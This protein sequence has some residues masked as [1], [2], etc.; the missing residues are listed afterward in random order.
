MKCDHI[1]IAQAAYLV[2]SSCVECRRHTSLYVLGQQELKKEVMESRASS[3]QEGLPMAK[4]EKKEGATWRSEC[5]VPAHGKH[6][7]LKP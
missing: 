5:L 3:S 2:E 4:R 6:G 7:Q 1:L